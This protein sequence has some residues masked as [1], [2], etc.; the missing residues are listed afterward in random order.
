M[1]RILFSGDLGAVTA[2]ADIVLDSL[3]VGPVAGKGLLDLG[4]IGNKC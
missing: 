1:F 4:L 3:K 2:P